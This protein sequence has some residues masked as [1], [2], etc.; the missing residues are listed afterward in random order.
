MNKT[1]FEVGEQAPKPPQPKNE[2]EVIKNWSGD[3]NKPL[4]SIVCHAYNHYNF[5]ENTIQSFLAQETSFPFEIIIHDDAS[6]DRT[7]EIINEYA[8]RYPKII[9]PIFQ[10][11]NQ[12]SKGNKPTGFTFKAA[13]GKYIALCEGDDYWLDTKKIQKQFDFLE[14]NQHI[15]ICGHDSLVIKDNKI[16]YLSKLP[17]TQKNDA[18]PNLI[19]N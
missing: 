8:K 7:V 11:E 6:T 12:F 16:I 3:L 10:N 9:K 17:A 19:H 1:I 14:K 5:I 15:S 18:S 4:V 13:K 2:A